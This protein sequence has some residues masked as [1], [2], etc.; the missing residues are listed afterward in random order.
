M[1][2]KKVKKIRRYMRELDRQALEDKRKI[3]TS[4][5]DIKTKTGKAVYNKIKKKL[6]K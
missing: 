1:N 2:A 4:K 6:T 3:Y 5:F